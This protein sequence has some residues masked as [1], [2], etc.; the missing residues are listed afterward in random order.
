M[1]R[2]YME[3]EAFRTLNLQENGRPVEMSAS[4]AVMRSIM[5][6]GIKGGRLSK[7][8]IFQQLRQEEKDAQ[9]RAIERY[10]SYARLKAEGEAEIARC[11]EAGIVPPRQYPHPDDILLDEARLEVH[12]LGPVTE[13]RAIPYERG[14]LTRDLFITLGVYAM[15][16]G[17]PDIIEIGGNPG[18]SHDVFALIVNDALPPSYRKTDASIVCFQMEL[19]WLSKKEI[20]ARIE[21]LKKQISSGPE[22]IEEQVEKRKR[23]LDAV[24]AIGDLMADIFAEFSEGLGA[25]AR[26]KD[27]PK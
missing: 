11:K 20:L 1:L 27:K 21:A 16:F 7:K 12:V 8:F 22:T 9:E 26:T 14:A 10:R 24:E 15:N 2:Q 5:N 17:S 23:N 6:D 18:R 3:K 4:E 19:S 13:D 25:Q